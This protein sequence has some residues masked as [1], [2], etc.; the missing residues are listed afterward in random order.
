MSVILPSIT[1]FTIGTTLMMTVRLSVMWM[2]RHAEMS[3]PITPC[4]PSDSHTGPAAATR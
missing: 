4:S 1:R 2:A 3:S